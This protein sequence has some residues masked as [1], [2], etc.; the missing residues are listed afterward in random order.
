MARWGPMVYHLVESRRCVIA[1]Q[2][3]QRHSRNSITLATPWGSYERTKIQ[4]SR[5]CSCAAVVV[6]RGSGANSCPSPRSAGPRS[7][8]GS[9]GTGGSGGTRRRPESGCGA[10][11]EV[12]T[13]AQGA[14][15][16]SRPHAREP[17]LLGRARCQGH[18]RQGCWPAR[19]H[20]Q[21][22]RRCEEGSGQEELSPGQPGATSAQGHPILEFLLPRTIRPHFACSF[23][24]RRPMRSWGLAGSM[25]CNG[26]RRDP[27]SP[28]GRLAGG[29]QET[30]GRF[31]PGKQTI[32]QS[33]GA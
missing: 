29:K 11:Q 3:V 27:G 4:T 30:S 7:A 31:W 33:C 6:W 14:A 28:I 23:S 21:V 22:R 10:R 32:F 13:C 20:A 15:A 18:S 12:G 16:C 25:F 1:A 8:A 17:R 5:R 2:S 24:A 19:R 26:C 9:C